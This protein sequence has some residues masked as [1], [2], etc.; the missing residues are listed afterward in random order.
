[1]EIFLSPL[2]T[3]WTE[4]HIILYLELSKALS[5]YSARYIQLDQISGADWLL[6]KRKIYLLLPENHC[7]HYVEDARSITTGPQLGNAIIS[8]P[9]ALAMQQNHLVNHSSG[10]EAAIRAVNLWSHAAAAARLLPAP[11]TNSTS[12]STSES[13]LFFSLALSLIAQ[14]AR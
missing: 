14:D 13:R 7:I 6:R 1:M 8:E 12:C 10:S 11:G 9:S 5:S 4:W 2:S 3:C